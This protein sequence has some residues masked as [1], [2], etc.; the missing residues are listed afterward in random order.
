MNLE[1][2]ENRSAFFIS[3]DG[4]E[5]L[6]VIDEFKLQFGTANLV[7]ES[8]SCIDKCQNEFKEAWAT[9]NMKSA[10]FIDGGV[11]LEKEDANTKYIADRV[12]RILAT[13]VII[14]TAVFFFIA[15]FNARS[16]AR[17]ITNGIVSLYETLE[18]I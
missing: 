4:V 16:V 8:Y 9:V 13:I 14:I 11:I 3:E 1:P 6:F 10:Y 18:N 12:D 7:E 2:S 5:Y 17:K 15:V